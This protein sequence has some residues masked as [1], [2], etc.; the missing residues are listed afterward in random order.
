MAQFHRILKIAAKVGSRSARRHGVAE[1][2]AGGLPATPEE[3]LLYRGGRLI[4]H[5]T[6]RNV[7]L[8]GPGAWAQDVRDTIDRALAAA[9]SDVHLN[10]VMMQYFDNNPISSQLAGS[11]VLSGPALPGTFAL[12]DVKRYVRNL[13]KQ[14]QLANL[15]LDH[16]VVNLLL[17]SGTL[18]TDND[19]ASQRMH[20]D[21]E[22]EA[23]LG[24]GIPAG[25]EA[26]SLNGLG[27]YHGSVHVQQPGGTTRTV[28]YAVGVFSE[29][30]AGGQEN[31]IV[32]FDQPWKNVVATFYHELNEARTDPDIDDAIANNDDGFCGWTSDPSR[33]TTDSLEVGDFPVFEAGAELGKVFKE[34][35]LAGESG[36]VPIQLMY[37][38][39]ARGPEGPI[40]K[41]HRLAASHV[42]PLN[43]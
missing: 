6:F 25:E 17:P 31:G 26:D 40:K 29:R 3:N 30:L 9:M 42:G 41:P 8:G 15:D 34:V 27:G 16:S 18:L 20:G 28:Y 24:P 38:N 43:T 22:P 2:R 35:H 37:S 11:L 13:L 10:N 32:A 7:Y 5:L 14:G 21:P 4:A 12:N 39:A 36:V 19:T 33:F 23:G 1:A